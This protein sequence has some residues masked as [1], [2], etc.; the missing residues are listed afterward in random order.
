MARRVRARSFTGLSATILAVL[1]F[2]M[3][4][5]A[6]ARDFP[7]IHLPAPARGSAALRALAAHLPQLAAAYGKSTD[8][9]ASIFLRDDT[10]W[11]DTHGRLFYGC[12]FGTPPVN[13]SGAENTGAVAE[14]P[15]PYDQ[16]FL[17]HSRPSATK[18]I[19]LDFD[20]QVTSGTAWN[21]NYNGGQDIVSAPFDLDGIPSSFNNAEMDAIQYIWQRVAE[22]YAPFDIDVTT[23]D[24][25]V[26]GLQIT[27]SSDVY[28][29]MRVVISPTNWYKAAAGG[30]AFVGVFNNLATNTNN[31]NYSPAWI[32][33]K[34]LGPNNEKYM[35][36][37]VSHE[38]GHTL[39]LHHD[40]VIGGSA[41][42]SGQGNWAP[43]MGV[44]YYKE[45]SQ[46]SKGEYANA[47]QTE[48]DLAV[49]Q[50]YGISYRADDHGNT[51]GT[52]TPLANPFVSQ[53]GVIET[54]TD[55]DTFSFQT[56]SGLIAFRVDPAPRGPNLDIYV[57]IYDG[58][59]NLVAS[60]EGAGLPA[61]LIATVAPGTYYLEIGGGGSG[62]P[63]TT[64]YSDYASL[65][66]YRI[67]ETVIGTY[68]KNPVAT[69][70]ASP[71]SGI[72]PLAVNFSSAGSLDPESSIRSYYWTFGDGSNSTE[73][74]PAHTYNTKGNYTA[75]LVVTDNAGLRAS[76]TVAMTVNEPI[77]LTLNTGGTGTT[78]TGGT[79]ANVSSGY[80][81]A[82]VDSG[83]TPYGTA[84]FSLSQNG[85]VVS[86]AGVPAS[87]P[88]QS[89]RIFI[90]YRTGVP[91]GVGTLDIYT[92]FA[93]AQRGNASATITYTLRDRSGQTVATGHGNLAVGA[94]FA[95]FIHE[96]RDVAPDFNLPASF[97]SATRF[98]SLEITSSQPV[99]VVALRLTTN[100]R[101]ETLLTSTPIADLSASLT[102][103][104]VYFPQ[105]A[106]GGG[107]ATTLILLNTS[108][109]TEAGT[110]AIFD[111]HGTPLALR[112]SGGTSGSAFPYSVPVGGAFVFQTDG[113][114]AA[115]RVG[116]VKLTPNSGNSAPVGAGVF[117][118][119]PAGILVTESGIPSAIPTTNARIYVDKSG[120]HDTGLAVA[121]PGASASSIVLQAF[122]NNGVTTAGNG[123][124]VLN[125]ASGGHAAKFVGEMIG[126]LPDGFTG[127]VRISSPSPFVALTLRSLS[128]SRGDFLLTT[129]PIADAN[130]PAPAPIVFPQ[131]AD[132]GGYTTQFI[133]ISATGSASI[134]VNF[135]GN[136]GSPLSFAGASP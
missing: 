36:E 103:S 95:K 90:D 26:E 71:T 31:S 128:N 20:G 5:P 68:E 32:F 131:I 121:N 113:S 61:T 89:A 27:S 66:Q 43:I 40:G 84:V 115:A 80:A 24:P 81:T 99:S 7:N 101:G 111:D 52:A 33:T 73:P 11:T 13:A 65:G 100:Q 135:R 123:Q 25:G 112:E 53:S 87:P 23:Q 50:T 75:T 49:M 48:D 54:R 3:G 98:G 57:R 35:A 92:G 47:N 97:P 58:T 45:V 133:F 1:L 76:A 119:S 132:G 16:T 106:D 44:S 60:N 94:H 15:L 18:V 134:T 91:A 2:T 63:L 59:G 136:D 114:P 77:R 93:I 108:N 127:V 42:Y 14:A 39:G 19:Y 105:L 6:Q 56:A 37:A 107:A 116:W 83:V 96:L 64:G 12:E 110:L 109:G 8:E 17:L 85:V 70:S 102:N 4:V 82:T 88:A 29:G 120:G 41:Y 51:I 122:Q 22:D 10:L 130:R 117:S 38:V 126:G 30:V 34:Q 21:S 72:L 74:S 79:A 9:L 104:P 124:A 118:Y 46:W 28:Y 55:V 129:F 86:E 67:T 62:D 78:S 69:A 125:I